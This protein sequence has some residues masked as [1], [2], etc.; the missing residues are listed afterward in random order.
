MTKNTN[1]QYQCFENLFLD[2][3]LILKGTAKAGESACS[4][5]EVGQQLK[6]Q[7]LSLL[8]HE[9]LTPLNGI[10]GTTYLAL[11]MDMSDEARE[12]IELANESALVLLNTIQDVLLLSKIVSGGFSMFPDPITPSKLMAAIWP[13]LLEKARA[14]HLTLKLDLAAN[15]PASIEIDIDQMR[16]VLLILIGNA[17]KFTEQGRITVRVE[18]QDAIE[19]GLHI[20]IADTG[21]GIEPEKLDSVFAPFIQADSGFTRKY[22]GLGIGLAIAWQLIDLMGGELVVDSELGKGSRFH[23]FLPR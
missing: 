7:S 14:K 4:S 6:A 1:C 2:R 23:I 3:R 22:D 18:P 19:G 15:L 12:L 10:I 20:C 17:I 9:L 8:S 21:I 11:D 13:D 5:C 16:R